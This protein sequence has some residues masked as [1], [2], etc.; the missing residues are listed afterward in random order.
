MA[1]VLDLM[2]I[3]EKSYLIVEGDAPSAGSGTFAEVGSVAVWKDG[4][5]QG[6]IYLK[7]GDAD[8]AWDRISTVKDVDHENV[9][10]RTLTEQEALAGRLLLAAQP[11]NP[12]NVKVDIKHGGG[13]QF[14]SE[15][16]TIEGQ[17]LIWEDYTLE[18]L[19]AQGDKVR[20]IY[21]SI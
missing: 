13:P 11:V 21:T 1:N 15:D 20:I 17:F 7:T 2:T 14:Y 10:Y 8:T 5:G 4:S 19:L 16:F 18:A 9:E 3:G 6:K 12:A